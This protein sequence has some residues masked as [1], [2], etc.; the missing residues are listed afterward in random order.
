MSRQDW[1]TP[2]WLF[3]LLDSR[4]GPFKLDAAATAD[5]ALCVEFS[6]DGLND[7]WVSPTFCNPP[8]KRFGDW[9]KKAHTEYIRRDVKSCLLGPTACSQAWFHWYLVD[10]IVLV[11]TSRISFCH[12]DGTPT[13]GAD[14]DTMIYLFG[15]GAP[16][17]DC[18]FMVRPIEIRSL[19]EISP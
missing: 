8:F 13:K 12:P 11:P 10:G 4:F 19:S 17:R 3:N 2:P 7:D 18:G 9:V 14:R 1:R 15:Y 6:S 5:N 16:P